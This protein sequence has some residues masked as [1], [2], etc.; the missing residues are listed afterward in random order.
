MRGYKTGLPQQYG[1]VKLIK[2]RQRVDKLMTGKK[3]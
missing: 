3:N 1:K 2:D